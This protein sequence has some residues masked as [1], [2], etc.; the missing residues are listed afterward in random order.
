MNKDQNEKELLL[1]DLFHK[2][3]LK[4]WPHNYIAVRNQKYQSRDYLNFDE[5]INHFIKTSQYD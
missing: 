2:L 5:A 3:P 1:T 4:Q